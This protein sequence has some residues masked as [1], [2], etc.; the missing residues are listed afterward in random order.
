MED[1]IDILDLTED[2]DV[3]ATENSNEFED[4]EDP[5]KPFRFEYAH[6]CLTESSSRFKERRNNV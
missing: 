3:L 2:N 5:S 4:L 6:E 1:Y